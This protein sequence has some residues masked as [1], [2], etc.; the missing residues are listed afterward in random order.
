MIINPILPLFVQS[1]LPA[2][3]ARVNTVVGV[4]NGIPALTGFLAAP[5]WGKGGDRY[6]H[7]R[8]LGLALLG[9]GLAYAPQALAGTIAVLALWRAL[10]GGFNSGIAPA[11][12]AIAGKALEPRRIGAA[13]S[14][15]TS[16]R[17]FGGFVGPVLGGFVA[18]YFGWWQVFVLTAVFQ[19]V[20]ASVVLRNLSVRS[21]PC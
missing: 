17:M 12:N 13:I 19:L 15:M 10:V 8:A 11:A 20:A 21:K 6:G 4:I 16:A 7:S 1:L 9:S 14:L 2:G 5:L 3:H 18:S